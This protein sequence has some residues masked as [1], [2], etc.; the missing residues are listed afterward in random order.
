VNGHKIKMPGSAF[1]EDRFGN[2][3]S[4]ISIFGDEFSYL[5]LGTHNELKPKK[6][7][8]SIWVKLN[9]DVRAGKGFEASPILLTRSVDE[10]DFCEAYTL[11]YQYKVG[12]L[13]G[14]C[15]RDSL[16]Q[17][18]VAS[19]S[20][21]KLSQWYHVVMS[22]DDNFFKL[23]INGK[24][25]RAATKNYETKFFENDS[26][27]VGIIHNVKNRRYMDGC[28][29]DIEFYDHI[30]SDEEI[31]VLYQS[32]DPNRR[33][34][35][36]Y[37]IFLGLTIIALI[38]FLYLFLKYRINLAN[39]KERQKLE[40]YNILLET[41]L[42]VNRALMNPH[43]VFNSLN[44]L[45]NF[46]LKNE[47][48]RANDYLVKFSKLM[49]KILENNMSDVISLEAEIDLL[50]K[51]LEIEDLRFE[52]DIVHSIIVDSGVQASSIHIPVMM[53]QPFVENAIW[54]GLLKKTGE[55]TLT[56]S[57]SMEGT[58]CLRCV[59][60]DNGLGRVKTESFNP[61]RKSLGISFIK[62]RLRLFNKMH[63]LNCSLTITDKPEQSGTVVTII[64]PIL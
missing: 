40:T 26:V 41:E 44:A 18:A 37:W 1:T 29:D 58:N 34:V 60:E 64:L 38:F 8:V 2:K 7:S 13:Y 9:R 10:L 11:T 39:Q 62:Q 45:Q 57:F 48:E 23:Y 61:E 56:I 36:V 30:L 4:A 55:K 6:G 52:E 53:L 3:N 35:V 15:N 63:K 14:G 43:F 32:P 33:K 22:Y 16:R 12:K 28:V 47:N 19:N 5:N 17:T 54:H 49:R 20:V 27:L 51:Y 24:L 50:L 59:I 31:T 25:Q 21:I 46:I 42:R